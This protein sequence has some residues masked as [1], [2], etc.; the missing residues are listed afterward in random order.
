MGTIKDFIHSI[1]EKHESEWGRVY[2]LNDADVFCNMTWNYSKY[3]HGIFQ[4]DLSEEILNREI[5]KVNVQ[6]NGDNVD[7]LIRI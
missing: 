6:I 3:K 2:I 1:L 4:S 7:Y 5:K